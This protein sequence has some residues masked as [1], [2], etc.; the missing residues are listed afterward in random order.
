[1]DGVALF[2]SCIP[3]AILDRGHVVSLLEAIGE[4][5]RILESDIL[6]DCGNRPFGLEQ[7]KLSLFQ[8]IV[9]QIFHRRY[10]IIVLHASR[11]IIQVEMHHVS[12][13]LIR[14]LLTIMLLQISLGPFRQRIARGMFLSMLSLIHQL[15]QLHEQ[16]LFL[17]EGKRSRGYC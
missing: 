2:L 8:T 9:K 4:V 5:R 10:P 17:P 1:M 14:E 7:Q 12:E 11:N 3:F 15:Q 6:C 13:R 16:R